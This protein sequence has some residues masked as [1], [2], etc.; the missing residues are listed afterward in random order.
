MSTNAN[1]DAYGVVIKINQPNSFVRANGKI[2]R[3][4]MQARAGGQRDTA[5]AIIVGDEVRID[6]LPDGSGRITRVLPRRNQL[7]RR[8]AVPMPS[9]HAHEQL[10]A[11]NL[12]LA[13]PVFAAANPAPRWHLLDRYLVLAEMV[14]LPALICITKGDLAYADNGELD[15][16]L[17]AALEE[18]RRI[19]Y[20]CVITCALDGTGLET[21]RG[22]LDGKVAIMLGKSGVGKSSLLNALQPDLEL[23]V[24][25]VNVVTGKGRHTTSVS[26]MYHLDSGGAIVDT[27]GIREFGLWDIPGGDLA[28][29]FPEMRRLLGLCRFGE[30]CQHAEEPG[31]AVRK[32]VMS[33]QVSPYRYQSYLKL[34]DEV[35]R[36]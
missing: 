36:Q 17:A 5:N 26:E 2:V 21:L 30:S 11:A 22:A 20:P 9:A 32:A 34:L 10:I 15:A 24:N 35:A 33:G 8:S 23:R 13:V 12:D 27:P 1:P 3:C 16:D 25:D 18:Y 6:L 4:T 28:Y 19:G 29:M 31:C 7:S 14:G